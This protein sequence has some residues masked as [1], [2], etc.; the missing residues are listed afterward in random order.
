MAESQ[1]QTPKIVQHPS[2][3]G[4]GPKV[5]DGREG[6]MDIREH[7]GEPKAS[8]ESGRGD[9]EA[10]GFGGYRWRG[11]DPR[12]DFGASVLGVRADI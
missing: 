9:E 4:W 10:P 3:L 2:G 12:C 6:S 11:V 5:R 8:R 1:A 7:G